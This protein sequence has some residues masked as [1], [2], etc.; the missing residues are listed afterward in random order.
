MDNIILHIFKHNDKFKI[1]IV[2]TFENNNKVTG[3][4][5]IFYSY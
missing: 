2:E 4:A 5:F 1:N 3:E